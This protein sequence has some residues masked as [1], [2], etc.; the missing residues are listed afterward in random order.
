ME[1]TNQN[2]RAARFLPWAMLAAGVY[3]YFSLF[4]PPFTPFDFMQDEGIFLLDATRM[5]HG[6][7]IYRD[8]FEF[9]TPGTQLIYLLLFKIWGARTWIPNALLMLL[10]LGWTWISIAISRKVLRG[11]NIYLPG[12]L[13]LTFA[14]RWCFA[15]TH[16]W[17]SELAILAAVLLL[18]EE[19]SRWRLALTGSLCGVASYFT[20]SQGLVALAG[21]VT[22]LWWESHRSNGPPRTLSNKLLTVALPFLGVT[23]V[24]N[25]YFV[26]KTGLRRYLD[27]TIVFVLRYYSQTPDNRPSVFVTEL[28]HVARWADLP[29]LGLYVFIHAL[30]LVYF[31]FLIYRR[32]EASMRPDQPWDRLTL[33]SIVGLFL[34]LGITSAP[35][36]VRMDTISLPAL[37]VLVWLLAGAAAP[38]RLARGGLWAAALLLLL[39]EPY[40]WQRHW[41]A[42]LDPPG[43]RVAFAIQE[44]YPPYQWVHQRTHAGDYFFEGVDADMYFTLGLTNPTE[45]PYVTPSDY[46]RPEQVQNVIKGLEEHQVQYVFWTRQLDPEAGGV[47]PGDH[48]E[49]LRNYLRDRY[50]VVK[51]FADHSEV[52]ELKQD[53]DTNTPL[54]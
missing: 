1:M 15:V 11:W 2:D 17:F 41:R 37:I 35:T 18:M 27:D 30:P 36:A 29:R 50:R 3:L 24:L 26:W 10:G 25:A 12:A 23:A 49:P 4:V 20:Q 31:A 16:H 8:F 7:M 47:A 40:H 21:F 34:F 39:L 51:T 44:L 14:F 48:L 22:F 5:L 13:F 19:R 28:P 32:R 33:L 43:G 53:N 42:Y 54:I 9:I 46:T 6:Q 38:L 45:V 52:W